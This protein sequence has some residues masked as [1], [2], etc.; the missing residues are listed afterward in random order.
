MDSILITVLPVFGLIVLGYVFARLKLLDS[1]TARGLT[2]FVFMLAIPALLFRTVAL[3][4]PLDAMP[5]GLWFAF[6]GG[7]ALTWILTTLISQK[8]D[9]LQASGGAE[10]GRAH[11]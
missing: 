5:F 1:A 4:K 9:S 11:V 2:Q 8:F 3:M 6:F 7:L 10:I